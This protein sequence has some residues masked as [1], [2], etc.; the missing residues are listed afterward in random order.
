MTTTHEQT[1]A[2]HHPAATEEQAI[3]MTVIIVRNSGDDRVE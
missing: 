1:T 3:G 2:V